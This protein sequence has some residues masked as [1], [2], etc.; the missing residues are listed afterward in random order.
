M[1]TRLKRSSRRSWLAC[2]LAIASCALLGAQAPPPTFRS[3]TRLIVQTVTVTDKEGH[4]VEGL[5]AKDFVVSEDG[6]PQTVS[7]VEFQRLPERPVETPAALAPS[8]VA[9]PAASVAPATQG[10]ISTP[11]P[12]DTR[13]KDRRLLILYFDLTAMPPADQMRAYTAARKFI[14]TEMQPSDVHWRSRA[15]PGRDR[16]ADL[17][18]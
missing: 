15:A 10:Q 2:S 7:F 6:E 12:G 1:E 4:P 8:A 9:P 17:R 16:H 11:P 18:R 3:G 14:G 13:Y 5:M